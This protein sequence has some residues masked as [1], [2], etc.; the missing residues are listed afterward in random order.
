MLS[1]IH[2]NT[3]VKKNLYQH[4]EQHN[5]LHSHNN[6]H[7][8]VLKSCSFQTASASQLAKAAKSKLHSTFHKFTCG[9]SEIYFQLKKVVL[10]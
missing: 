4:D 6:S 7:T 5:I 2:F 9:K 1:Y 8:S 3:H 10:L